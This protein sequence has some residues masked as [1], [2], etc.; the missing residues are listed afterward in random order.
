[1]QLAARQAFL[2]EQQHGGSSSLNL[3]V[4]ILFLGLTGAGKTQ[5]IYSLLN[6]PADEID[7]FHGSTKSVQ[8]RWQY[9]RWHYVR[10]LCA[11]LISYCG[12]AG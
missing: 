1:M 3:R 4:K 8:V 2:L 9:V 10:W 7:P 6:K 12:C 11:D 5:L